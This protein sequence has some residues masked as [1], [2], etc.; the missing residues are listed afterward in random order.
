MEILYKLK[1]ELKYELK[2][3]YCLKLKVSSFIVIYF[4]FNLMFANIRPY[5]ATCV[6]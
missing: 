4:N 3:K 5:G 1:Y 2:S 6:L